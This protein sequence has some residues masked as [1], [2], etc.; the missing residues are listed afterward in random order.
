LIETGTLAG[1]DSHPPRFVTRLGLLLDNP[2]GI[3]PDQG[4]LES[5]S[6]I[7]AAAEQSGFDSLWVTDRVASG[8]SGV[9]SGR[10]SA[11][12]GDDHRHVDPG[13][14]SGP[15][16]DGTRSTCEAYSLLGAL[17]IR[18]SSIRLGAWPNQL[19]IRAPSVLSKIVTAVDV[20]SKG[21]GIVTLACDSNE[22]GPND[23]E[24]LEEQLV[25]CRAM[26]DGKRPT[27]AGRFYT[28]DGAVN[29]PRPVQS[30][31][32]PIVVRIAGRDPAA[33]PMGTVILRVAAVHADAVVVA[34]GPDAV[35][36]A[37]RVLRSSGQS[38]SGYGSEFQPNHVAVIWD[39]TIAA[40]ESDERR[41]I[42][43]S[44]EQS[45]S[46]NRL[47]DQM[48]ELRRAGADGCV[49]SLPI[50]EPLSFLRHASRVE[51]LWR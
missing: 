51:L 44:G 47:A 42:L 18:T 27:W 13:D 7:A 4:L 28:I 33:A 37:R 40:D 11:V 9:T 25:L 14:T 5:A 23:V 35:A 1:V 50:R 34:G 15:G 10:G 46:P 8:A 36:D 45:I 29:R 49:L 39:G 32:V 16:P 19:E 38:E 24:R 43:A 2:T 3:D 48:S 22:F 30:G 20:I 26:L 12:E 6:A 21:R 31:G 41:A 17:A